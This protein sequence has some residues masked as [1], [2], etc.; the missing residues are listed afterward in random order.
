MN[1]E[2]PDYDTAPAVA[3]HPEGG[4]R[5]LLAVP[6]RRAHGVKW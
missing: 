6:L 1:F 5:S 4:Y 2:K 3:F